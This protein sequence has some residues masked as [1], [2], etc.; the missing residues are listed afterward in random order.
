M[1][2]IL[3]R[4]KCYKAE[5]RISLSAAHEFETVN[6]FLFFLKL[7]FYLQCYYDIC[8]LNAEWNIHRLWYGHFI[9]CHILYN[10]EN[11]QHVYHLF[12]RLFIFIF[13]QLMRY[14]V[15]RIRYI[16][17]AVSLRLKWVLM[18]WTNYIDRILYNSLLRFPLSLP[19]PFVL[20][21]MFYS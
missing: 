9:I 11:A 20:R 19:L 2:S 6:I 13:W 7:F 4:S 14:R 8:S 3:I 16:N 1:T 15:K 21:K 12:A 5:H 18:L 10:S 17:P